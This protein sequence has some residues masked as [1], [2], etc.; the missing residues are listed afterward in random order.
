MMWIYVFRAINGL[1]E[2][3]LSKRWCY[4]VSALCGFASSIHG[5]STAVATVVKMRKTRKF[6]QFKT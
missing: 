1:I 3:E 6:V 5:V 4:A 2:L